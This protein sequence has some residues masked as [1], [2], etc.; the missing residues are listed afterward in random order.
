[1]KLIRLHVEN[2]GTLK[3]YRM[4]FSK[5]LNVLHRENGWGKSTLAVFIKAMLYGLPSSGKRS[6]DENERK[7]YIPWQGGA[8]GGSLEFETDRG[9]FRVERFFGAKESDDEVTLYDLSTN[10]PT[11]VYQE[12]IGE[13]L[14]GID[15]E[16]F[17]R[18]VY[19][20]QRSLKTGENLSI[21]EKLNGLLDAVDDLGNYDGAIAALDKRRQYYEKTG[22]RGRIA[23]LEQNHHDA[24][25][26]L[27]ELLGV[28]KS[29]IEKEALYDLKMSELKKN[30]TELTNVRRDLGKA[31]L[32][33]ERDAHLTHK[34]QM[35]AELAG[36]EK[37]RRDAEEALD[38]QHPTDAELEQAER[39]LQDVRDAKARYDAIPAEPIRREALRILPAR[40]AES[41]P[42][43]DLILRMKEQNRSLEEIFMRE[44]AQASVQGNPAWRRFAQGAPSD[45]E[46]NA[47][48]QSLNAAKNA[49]REAERIKSAPIQKHAPALAIVLLCLGAVL[50]VVSALWFPLGLIG[51][52]LCIVGAV[53]GFVTHSGKNKRFLVERDS[54]AEAKKQEAQEQLLVLKRFL[55]RYGTE[56]H[57]P[58]RELY[59]LGADLRGYRA[60][61]AEWETAAEERQARAKEKQRIYD[62]LLP[63]LRLFGIEAEKQRSYS[64]E[65]EALDEDVRMLLRVKN[66]EADRQRKRA[67]ADAEYRDCQSRIKPFLDRFDPLRK[68]PSAAACLER[69]KQYER[70]FQSA[71]R[72]Y[73]IKQKALS[74][75]IR[76]KKLDEAVDYEGL[77]YDALSAR[78]KE[79][80]GK[81]D[82]LKT[83]TA[84]LKSE[85]DNLA[86]QADGLDAV[87]ADIGRLAEEAET[88]TA[89]LKTV[90]LT[91]QFL[92]DAKEALSTRYLSGMQ[93]SFARFLA[94]LTSDEAP[95]SVMDANFNVKLREDGKTREIESFSRGWRDAVQFCTRLSLADALYDE[96]EKPFLLLDD[97]FVNLDDRRLAAARRMLDLLAGDYQIVYM[98]CHA[99]RG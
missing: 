37:K 65:L 21:T 84:T 69:V 47:A 70:D 91:K 29:L 89:N 60:A 19:L 11:T 36:L 79:L 39:D 26:E 77:D 31:G 25:R 49:E 2:F 97:P 78:Q 53:V 24:Q 23:E 32:L 38:G 54:A 58:E 85:I 3:D 44:E 94:A 83:E 57:D 98:V 64:T 33:R 52:A 1:M 76:E 22:N 17:E 72:D 81:C 35:L 28:Q 74:D 10:H 73:H 62:F 18:T 13:S 75:F 67:R 41:V 15:A 87:Q 66:E 8:F 51:A 90:K 34:N 93:K 95:E 4:E 96:G 14:F 30:E 16:G 27:E 82:D 59:E 92:E 46:I 48:Y 56:G 5:G 80:Q 12:P 42:N 9:R 88:A 6:L 86:R 55:S 61:R 50:A 40:M 7:K 68:M 71:S 20:S 63:T 99:D 45:A 43:A